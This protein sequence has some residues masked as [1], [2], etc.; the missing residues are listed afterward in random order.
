MVRSTVGR[1]LLATAL[2]TAHGAWAQNSEED[3]A[4]YL[5]EIR[6]GE[7]AAQDTLGNKTISED[8]IEERNPST[9]REV[10]DGESSVTTSGGAAISTKVFV[11]GIEESLLS[12]TIDGA[13]QNKSAFHHTG[14]VL[15]DPAMLK[16]VEIS[17]GLAPADAGPG[18]AAGSIAYT[19]KDAS[20]LLE[21][22]DSFGGR[23]S[24]T[25]G[26]NGYGF[27]GNL[28]LF[29]QAQGFD[30]LLS[31]TYQHGDDYQDGSGNTVPGTAADIQDY[32]AKFSYT[33][34]NGGKLTFS[35]SQTEDTGPRAAQPGPGGLLFI[36]PDFAGVDG[37]DSVII[38]GLSRRTS[39]S[40][41]YTDETPDGWWDPF[42]QLAYNEQEIDAG[43]VYGVNKS[44]SGVVRNEFYIGNGTLTAGIDFFDDSA[45]GEGDAPLNSTGKET[46]Q[47]I[48]L[49]AQARQNLGQRF[50]VSYGARY[51]FQKFEG[52]DGTEFEDGG[53]SFNGSVDYMLSDIWTINAGLSHGWGGYELGEAALVNFGTPWDYTGFTSS[54]SK[55]ARLGLRFD[56]GVW[57]GS[58]ALFYTEVDDLSAV[59]P[60]SGARGATADITSQGVDA[61]L[62]Y[63][64]SSGFARVNYTYAD[65]DINGDPASTT[66]YYLG[67]PLGSIFALEA[68]WDIDDQ[69][70]VGGTAEIALENSDAAVDLPGYQVLNVYASYVPRRFDNLELRLDVRNLFD[71]TY[72]SRASDGL[73][74]SRVIPLTEPGRTITLT[75]ALWF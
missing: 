25:G 28:S 16:Q 45:E 62:A 21:P 29:G 57:Q 27:R 3:D 43:G 64:W 4:A 2:T 9:L 11:N 20:D 7:A 1:L 65:V 6:I 34:A 69:W 60:S 56:T 10:F 22:G 23:I 42:I 59:L 70:R 19:T 68:G 26:D 74:S 71:E 30:Y 46:L 61:S 37:T 75:A 55:S 58:A 72:S 32:L 13:R 5:G 39:F 33:A 41:T 73:D 12:V 36:R 53:F 49:F 48:G 50:S 54:T 8:E 18:A 38:D 24:L 40:L 66:A 35:A 17:A 47:G 51:D 15:L 67:R 44:L 31:G 63:L 14:N 52:A